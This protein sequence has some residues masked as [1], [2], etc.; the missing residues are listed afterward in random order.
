MNRL[1]EQ[2]LQYMKHA[3]HYQ[4]VSNSPFSQS[5]GHNCGTIQSGPQGLNPDCWYNIILLSMTDRHHA[6]YVYIPLAQARS[7]SSC[8]ACPY[9]NIVIPMLDLYTYV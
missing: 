1:H 6:L 8:S 9:L 4:E 5:A 3:T 7:T 2:F